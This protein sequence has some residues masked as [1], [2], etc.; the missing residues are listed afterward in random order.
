MKG[1]F[2]GI[3]T[4]FQFIYITA[5]VIRRLEMEVGLSEVQAITLGIITDFHLYIRLCMVYNSDKKA[6][7][8]VEN[9]VFVSNH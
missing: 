7:E 1:I 4:D 5:M 8:S 6:L 9:A 3:I 2:L